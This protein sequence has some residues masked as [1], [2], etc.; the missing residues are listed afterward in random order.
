MSTERPDTSEAVAYESR[1]ARLADVL[2]EMENRGGCDWTYDD[3]ARYVNEHLAA[4][5]APLVDGTEWGAKWSD[6]GYC[7]TNRS[8]ESARKHAATL[9]TRPIRREVG[10]WVYADTHEHV[11]P[12]A[13]AGTP[14]TETE[15]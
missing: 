5:L 13:D 2:A 10:P 9:G 12:E 6:G 14:T 3:Q 1:I 7:P 4:A 15:A 11:F 8:E